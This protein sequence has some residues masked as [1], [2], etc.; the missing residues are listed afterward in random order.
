MKS[1][2]ISAYQTCTAVVEA[3]MLNVPRGLRRKTLNFR[4]VSLIASSM[5]A[6][7]SIS[8]T[9][10]SQTSI[11]NGWSLLRNLPKQA[12]IHVVGTKIDKTCNFVSADDESLVCSSGRTTS[13]ARVTFSRTAVKTVKL[14]FLAESA[15]TGASIR[16]ASSDFSGAATR[17]GGPDGID[18]LSDVI[19]GA[20]ALANRLLT[21][22]VGKSIDA[23]RGSTVYQSPKPR[24]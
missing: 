1:A 10:F 18:H 24:G 20:A 11:D 4:A 17:H 15:L 2:I 5:I 19:L 16:T 12:R 8:L 7:S 6:A 13:A 23:F 3:L 21:S 22:G 9:A 14:T